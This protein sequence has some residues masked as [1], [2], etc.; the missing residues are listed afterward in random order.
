M[1]RIQRL[2]KQYDSKFHYKVRSALAP[3][4]ESI[5][6]IQNALGIE[7]PASL[8]EFARC[9]EHYG[10]WLAS[11]GPDFDSQT[12]ILNI[13]KEWRSEV[14]ESMRLPSEYVIINVGYDEDF[15]CLDLSTFDKDTGE[16]FI[17]Y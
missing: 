2:A 10:D 17:A 11:L 3:T 9:S 16:Y 8:I 4:E 13:N 5:K 14:E 1:D 12:H 15:D 7:L 6:F